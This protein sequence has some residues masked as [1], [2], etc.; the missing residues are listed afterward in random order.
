MTN[1][2]L[3][4]N[5]VPNAGNTAVQT[6][7]QPQA[8]TPVQPQGANAIAGVGQKPGVASDPFAAPRGVGGGKLTEALNQGVVIRPTEYIPSM[9]TTKGV[10]D[11]IQ[12]D[13]IILTG[14]NQ[15]QVE[16]G[17]I[18]QKV[19]KSELKAIMGTPTPMMVGV[20]HLGEERNGNNAPYLLGLADDSV[21]TLAAQ[22]AQ[23]NNW[24]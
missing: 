19:L 17:L 20:L 5:A 3:A 1:P 18:F 13:W 14:P 21:R 24:I 4:N 7:V 10:T 16:S 8:Q 11:A 15:G 23:A 6:P 2:F 9:N 12:A 22:A